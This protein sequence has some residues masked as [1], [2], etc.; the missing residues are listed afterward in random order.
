LDLDDPPGVDET[1]DPLGGG[2]VAPQ[3]DL[4][5]REVAD[6]AQ[7]VVQLVGAACPTALRHAL[8]FEL[9]VGEH[10]GVEEFTKL[11]GAQQVAQQVA[12][13]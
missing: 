13:E 8:Q 12:I 2:T 4:C 6:L 1:V 10:T 11:L 7:H 9:D 5:S 3:I